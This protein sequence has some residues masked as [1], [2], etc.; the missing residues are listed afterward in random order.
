MKLKKNDFLSSSLQHI[1]L[2][3]DGDY[4]SAGCEKK[5]HVKDLLAAYF[6]NNS[7]FEV[8]GCDATGT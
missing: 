6:H 3:N 5:S 1:L 4:E 8:Y 2:D 7:N